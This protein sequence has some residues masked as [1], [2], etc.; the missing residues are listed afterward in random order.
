MAMGVV[1]RIGRSILAPVS[2]RALYTIRVCCCPRDEITLN[3]EPLG[4]IAFVNPRHG[5]NILLFSQSA[6]TTSSS[7]TNQKPIR[8]KGVEKGKIMIDSP[9]KVPRELNRKRRVRWDE[10]TL[11]LLFA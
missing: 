1:C 7:A 9:V 8:S 10:D 5:L 11:F 3:C 6:N 4:R 2:Y